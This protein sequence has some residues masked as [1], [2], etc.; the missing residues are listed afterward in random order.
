MKI[1]AI[2]LL[3]ILSFKI[4]FSQD[5]I[6]HFIGLDFYTNNYW[7]TVNRIEFKKQIENQLY[8]Q[9][10]DG[11]YLL[12]YISIKNNEKE[13][14]ILTSSL[15]NL[16]DS[17]GYIYDISED[18]TKALVILEPEK[19]FLFKK[20]PPRI[21]KEI[22]VAFEVP[23]EN[24]NYILRIA[25][26]NNYAGFDTCPLFYYK[27]PS[28]I[29]GFIKDF[30]DAI[31]EKDESKLV[32]LFFQKG[33]AINAYGSRDECGGI[34]TG[35]KEIL[36]YANELIEDYWKNNKTYMLMSETYFRS[37]SGDKELYN[38]YFNCFKIKFKFEN[39][40]SYETYYV[41]EY[42]LTF[43]RTYRLAKINGEWKI[44]AIYDQN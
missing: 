22:I 20:L 42:D 36:E 21:T 5:H 28:E 37:K 9:K 10:A 16:S 4:A 13:S 19:I 35:D 11:I 32:R 8:T 24:D 2:F 25:D 41:S 38:N 34:I 15:F 14:K 30:N 18:A 31:K 6:P 7:I 17:K 27:P 33:V 29:R 26:T 1:L 23:D 12:V 40:Y 39:L 3:T 43:S 44:F